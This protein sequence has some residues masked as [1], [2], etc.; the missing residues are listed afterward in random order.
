MRSVIKYFII[1]IS[2]LSGYHLKAQSDELANQLMKN[3]G[4]LGAK[5]KSQMD[6]IDFQ[7]AISINENAGF[8]DIAQK[9]EG[10]AN[11][12]YYLKDN[13]DK[14]TS[15]I[16]RDSLEQAINLYE[17]RWYKLAEEAFLSSQRFMERNNLKEDVNYLRCL[18]NIGLVY[19]AQGRSQEAQN[20][21]DRALKASQDTFGQK[22]AAY[23]TNLNSH[24]KLDQMLGRY[25]EAEKAFDETLSLVKDVFT[26]KSMQ[27]AIVLNNKAMLFQSMGRYDEGITLMKQA[28]TAAES[29]PKKGLQGKKSFDSRK[30]QANL[31]LLYQLSGKLQDAENTFATIRKVFE[32]R[33]QTNNLEYASLL[34]QM[35]IL[36]I[37]MDKKE[38]VEEMLTKSSSIYKKKVGEENPYY[39]KAIGDLG[40]YYRMTTRYKEAEPLLQKALGVRE[41]TLGPYHP[42]YV[43]TKEDLAILYWKTQQWDKAYTFYKETMDQTIEFINNYFPPMS[44]AE[45]T[46]YWD[47]TSPRFQR[48]FNF[49]IDAIST[50]PSIAREIFDYHTATKALLLNSTNKVKEAILKS[51]NKALVNEYLSWLDKKE[52]LS[53]YYSLSKEE[54]KEQNIDLSALEAESNRIERSLSSKSSDF[55]SGY[56]AQKISFKQISDLLTDTEAAVEL[57]RVRSYDQDF[58]ND[59]R[60]VGLIL[61]KGIQLP[62]VVVLE[63]GL[64]LETRYAKYYRNAI[65]QKLLDEYSYDQYWAKLEPAIGSKKKVYLSFDGVFNQV[66]LNTLKKPGG[67][68]VLN[69]YDLVILGN[70]KDLIALKSKKASAPKKNTML[71]GFPDYGGDNI[72]ALPGTKVEIENITKILKPAG[73]QVTSF[74]QANA[75]EKNL[76]TISGPALM[77]IATHG[78]FLQ[79]IEN[80]DNAFGVHADNAGNNPLLRSGLL[81]AGA[82]KTIGGSES[83][84]IESNDN[85]ILTAYEAMNLN[86]EGTE[87]IVLSAC[88]TGLGDVKNGEG[89]YGLQRAFLVAGADAMIMSLWKVDDAATQLLM[90]NFYTSWIKLKDKQ[91][92]FKQAQL[93]LMIKYK[94]PYYWGAFVMM[95]M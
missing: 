58:T 81:L 77:H 61:T 9:G 12:L 79:D 76:K 5:K 60:Y 23:V 83:P 88:E 75:S 42:D 87:L 73:Y 62:D 54:L 45:K 72:A 66:N 71:L 90:T 64:Q 52:T 63:N 43:R 47:I 10:G 44:E 59:S 50:N 2:L 15:E 29:A 91:K 7:F 38:K 3:L 39:A 94:E 31:A 46:K 14:T 22:S 34:N 4:S 89:V 25:N 95:G 32:N 80:A 93:Q 92:A 86:L 68:Y 36:Y 28:I 53:R 70:S 78:Y 40:N 82:S 85:G 20:Y 55:S 37:Q 11:A 84:N 33:A 21:I 19:L 69:R 27:Y 65:Q 74:T 67:D 24:A 49:A 57:I 17:M 13:K 48:F 56:S 26:E 1:V 41:R 30:F 18:S 35:A 8:F 51:G 6:S 16:A